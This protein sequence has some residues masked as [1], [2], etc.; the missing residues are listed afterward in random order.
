ML[1]QYVS[2]VLHA[3]TD[4]LC[5]QQ[6]PTSGC[7]NMSSLIKTPRKPLSISLRIKSNPRGQP[8]GFPRHNW[9]LLSKR[10]WRRQHLQHL[11][12]MNNVSREGDVCAQSKVTASCYRVFKVS[13]GLSDKNFFT[14]QALFF[15]FSSC[16]LW[17]LQLKVDLKVRQGSHLLHIAK[18]LWAKLHSKLQVWNCIC[19]QGLH[20]CLGNLSL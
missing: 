1:L 19:P 2:V 7:R 20:F 6:V 18:I 11:V 15:F 3:H 16:W 8:T 10:L 13:R 5:I 12:C 17:K 14:L 4:F 9:S